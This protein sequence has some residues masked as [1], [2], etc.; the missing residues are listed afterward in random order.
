MNPPSI[1]IH[2][3]LNWLFYAESVV[4]SV[5]QWHDFIENG[6]PDL[7]KQGWQITID[8]SFRL[9]ID[10]ADE[11]HA[12]LDNEGSEWF[13]LS[14]GVELD[15]VHINLLPTLVDFLSQT[16]SP[17]ATARTPPKP[18]GISCTRR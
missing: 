18:Y 4:Q 3:S 13:S 9:R 10:E 16:G 6:L 11:W 5:M 12:E 14:L 8:E 7:R 1:G 17:R 15:G 2:E